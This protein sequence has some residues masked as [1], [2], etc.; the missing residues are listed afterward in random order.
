MSEAVIIGFINDIVKREQQ[1]YLY[2]INKPKDKK[3][4][5]RMQKAIDHSHSMLRQS[6]KEF[7]HQDCRSDIKLNG[8]TRY[9]RY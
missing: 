8:T 9:H 2:K 7:A 1:L 5:K 3:Q 6:L 4:H